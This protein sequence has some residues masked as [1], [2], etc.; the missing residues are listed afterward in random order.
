MET[1]RS[2][3]ASR[4]GLLDQILKLSFQRGR[5]TLSSGAISDYYL[6]LRRTTLDPHGLRAAV[7][8]LW[9]VI[10][11]EAITAVGGPTLGADPIVA[12]LILESRTRGGH[13]Q[14]FLVRPAV[15]DHG[16]G[17]QIEGHCP[18][19]ARVAVLDDVVTRGGSILR[20][21]DAARS[22]GAEVALALALVDR[23][24]GGR[25][26]L[27]QEGIRL[28]APL[29]VAQVLEEAARRGL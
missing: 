25:Q 19:G 28:F 29:R 21:V 17:R 24:E 5:F 27:E 16:T 13:L 9:P 1:N 26:A 8:A 15:K 23:E 11:E 10:E 18:A 2:T 22:A 6:D 3:E 20:A 7:E 4:S 14:G 12:G